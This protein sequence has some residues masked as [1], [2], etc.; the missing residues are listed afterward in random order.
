[1]TGYDDELNDDDYLDEDPI[2]GLEPRT[3]ESNDLLDDANPFGYNDLDD[4]DDYGSDGE[5]S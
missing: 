1:M 3:T 2:D 5:E 4:A